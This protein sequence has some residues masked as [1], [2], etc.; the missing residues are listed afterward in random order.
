MTRFLIIAAL[1]L[2]FIAGNFIEREASERRVRH[3]LEA[4]LHELLCP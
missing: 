1:I 3:I 4:K 2:A